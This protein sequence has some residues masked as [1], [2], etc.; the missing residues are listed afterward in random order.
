M[1]PDIQTIFEGER[2]TVIKQR[3]RLRFLRECRRGK[4]APRSLQFKLP[5]RFENCNDLKWKI[6]REL[7]SRTIGR[8]V[9]E[10]DS[11][12]DECS[13]RWRCLQHMVSDGLVLYRMTR[14]VESSVRR[15]SEREEA[16]L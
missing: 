5:G 2:E 1:S 8:I 7:I 4:L 10:L 14:H 11:L 12:V 16:M 9:K 13:L 6:Q 3:R 15:W